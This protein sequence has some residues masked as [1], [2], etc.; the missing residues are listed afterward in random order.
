M[1]KNKDK[2]DD[3]IRKNV[4]FNLIEVVLL[5]LI[6]SI[7][8]GVF[9]GLLVY[10]NYDKISIN[11]IHAGDNE[12]FN[13]FIESYNNIIDSYVKEVD[14]DK[15][16]EA[17]IEGMYN[18]LDDDYSF[19]MDESTTETLNEQLNGEYSGIGVEI[20]MNNNNEVIV[21]RV[22]SDSPALDAGLKEGD[23]LIGLDG[24]DLS[25]KDSEYFANAVKES[26]KKSFDVTYK[27]DGKSYTVTIE[28]KIVLID[29]VT[30]KEY[31]NIGYIQITT[32]SGTTKKQVEDKISKFSSNVDSVLIDLRNNTGGYLSA[33]YE[34]SDLFIEKGKTIYQLKDKNGNIT[35]YNAKSGVK[36]EFKKIGV[37]VNGA[38]A[39]AS[40]ILAL[41]LKES[42]NAIIMGSK[43]YGKGTVQETE[44]L[45]SGAMVKY[46]TAYWLSPNGNSIN[47]V[48]IEPD[49]KLTDNEQII[50]NAIGAMK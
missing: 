5:V 35:K 19:Y 24:V 43:S 21:K 49:I 42:A 36:K 50:N 7:F 31:G 23:I 30:S 38:S 28:R 41:A 33:A 48:G 29:S 1:N 34:I 20:S 22:F 17:A 9:C 25:N 45:S 2:K 16:I 26:N 12:K 14:E 8:F 4:Q 32:F 13:E 46:T 6:S 10:N 47:E 3:V 11:K 37:I 39:S 18:Y 44:K 15:L 27:R 40:E